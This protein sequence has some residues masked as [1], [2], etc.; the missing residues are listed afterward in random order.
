[1]KSGS[2]FVLAVGLI[3][4]LIV[5]IAIDEKERHAFFGWIADTTGARRLYR[6]LFNNP[7]E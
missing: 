2:L 4:L 1:M 6:Y 5:V 7:W 3:C